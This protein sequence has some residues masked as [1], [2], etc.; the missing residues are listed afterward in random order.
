MIKDKTKKF[1]TPS[2]ENNRKQK[3]AGVPQEEDKTKKKKKTIRP[4]MGMEMGG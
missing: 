1:N 3:K 4:E 2:D